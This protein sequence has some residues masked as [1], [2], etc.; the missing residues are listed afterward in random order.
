MTKKLNKYKINFYST[1]SDEEAIYTEIFTLESYKLRSTEPVILMDIGMNVGIA[2][3][4]F[5]KLPNVQKIYGYEPFKNTYNLA[6]EN[7]DLNPSFKNKI[8]PLNVGISDKNEFSMGTCNPEYKGSA[9]IIDGISPAGNTFKVKL[10]SAGDELQRIINSYPDTSIVIKM[11]CEGG[12]IKIFN[13][14]KFISL[15]PKVKEI[16][17]ETHN[18][19]IYNKIAKILS[20][21][22][23]ITKK[24]LSASNGYIHA[25]KKLNTK[26]LKRLLSMT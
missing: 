13:D 12:E 24:M 26:N 23:S 1:G 21:D 6:L 10:K 15:L 7:F 5:A 20:K 25:V 19:E 2:S 14:P 16:V 3:L 22:F 18:V 4:Y 17:M 8:V 9:S 11:D